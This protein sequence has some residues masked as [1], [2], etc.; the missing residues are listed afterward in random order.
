LIKHGSGNQQHERH[1]ALLAHP[2]AGVNASGGAIGDIRRF[3]DD[4]YG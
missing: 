2:P 1:D 3:V 4:V